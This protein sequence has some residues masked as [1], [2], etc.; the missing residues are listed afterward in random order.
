MMVPYLFVPAAKGRRYTYY[1]RGG[2][3]HRIEGEYK[4]IGSDV[5]ASDEWWANYRRIHAEHE[6]P[7]VPKPGMGTLKAVIA[8]YLGST[9]FLELADK[10]KK[11]YRRYLDILSESYGNLP[12][13]TMPKKFVYGLRDKYIG[14]PGVG[15]YILAVL[16]IIMGFAVAR[17][18]RADNPVIGVR[19]P[20]LGE[21][22][23]PWDD[24]ELGWFRGA[25]P[26]D[27]VLALNLAV[28][29]GQREGDVLAMTWGQYDGSAI[30]V[31]QQKT[32]AKVWIPA[33]SA[34][35]S[36]LANAPRRAVTILTAP[37]G[38]PWKPDHFRHQ[39]RRSIL[40]A[41]LDGKTFHGLRKTAA[42]ALAESGCSD[43]EIMAISGHSTTE[44]IAHYT[45]GADQKRRAKSAIRKL[46][47]R[48]KNDDV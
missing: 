4:I 6:Q 2:K 9:E 48:G 30:E 23:Q 1:R 45:I 25:A 17:E 13:S 12:I 21:G 36:A 5:T 47:E 8:E 26:A 24:F 15:R 3:L 38:R 46:E 32:G 37:G 11:D 41:G 20:R 33:H 28:Y 39:W 29:T 35:R 42:A 31:T 19:M 27:M 14:R 7:A 34:L 22:N 40:A 44:M 10:T 16:K 18:Y 43:R